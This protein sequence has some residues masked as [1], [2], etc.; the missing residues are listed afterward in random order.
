MKIKQNTFIK[1]K[2]KNI[3]IIGF[4]NVAY[5]ID[6]DKRLI[7]YSHFN[8][9]RSLDLLKN[10]E[11]VLDPNIKRIKLPSELS[12]I[13]KFSSFA[14]LYKKHKSF[15]LVLVL[16]PTY[17]TLKIINKLLDKIKMKYLL[18]EKPVTTNLNSFLSLKKDLNKQKII[19]MVNYQRNF[20][21]NILLIKKFIS[22]N[23]PYF[24]FLE[25]SNAIIQSG[26]HFIE[27]V[28]NLFKNVSPIS[29]NDTSS[30]H[31]IINGKKDPNGVMILKSN[32]TTILLSFLGSPRN[33]LKSNILIR[34]E[35][36]YLVFNEIKGKIEIGNT[37]MDIKKR[38]ANKCEFDERPHKKINLINLNPL[39][40]SY[41]RFLNQTKTDIQTTNR[42]IKV[43]E[44]LNKFNISY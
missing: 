27:L 5:R 16:V 8:A 37:I 10:V 7:K 44:I 39:E 12:H 32:S 1:Y 40:L 11:A 28:L 3:L 17:L 35:K 36:K 34:S 38:L 18:L 24:F 21:S 33:F 14:D 19:W 4:G 41:T 43:V 29:F 20:D 26:T 42:A 13:S 2:P 25:T 6:S 9:L 22:K 15:D 31:R 30:S 23:K